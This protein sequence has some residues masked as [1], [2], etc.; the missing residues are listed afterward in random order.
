M[1]EKQEV[2]TEFL[3]K[4]FKLTTARIGQLAAE[5]VLVRGSK[6]GYYIL[7]ESIS[8][9]VTFLQNHL[10]G[11]ISI[12]LQT[13]RARL[14]KAQADKTEIEIGILRGE[15]LPA[16]VVA[17]VW[18]GMTSAARAR[19]LAL[20]YR[21]ATAA[22]AA[23][24]FNKIE[25]AATDLITEA[26]QELHTFNPNDY[27]P[28]ISNEPATAGDGMVMEAAAAPDGQSVGRPRKT[29]KPRGQR[30]TRPVAH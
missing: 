14:A 24:S 23:D 17:T 10:P 13:E 7:W 5:G 21:L 4:L 16:P 27:Q 6:R 12:D 28:S 1:A 15:L 3:A 2:P 26:L 18:S 20:P 9:Y 29:P 25:T 22:I 30:R 8:G 11:R 19:L